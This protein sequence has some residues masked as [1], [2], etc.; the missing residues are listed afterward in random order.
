MIYKSIETILKEARKRVCRNIQG[1]MVFVY[2]QIGKMI[3]VKQDG[4]SR[5]KYGDGLI[6]ELSVQLTNDF[7]KG[8]NERNPEQMRRFYLM[9]QKPNA[10]RAELSWTHHF[11]SFF[12]FGPQCI[13]Y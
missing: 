12:Q 1:E 4:E 2:W 7:G 3:V 13:P 11:I 5:A 10:V 8:F 6:K 9:F